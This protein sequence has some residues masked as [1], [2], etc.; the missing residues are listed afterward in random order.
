MCVCV[1]FASLLRCYVFNAAAHE[2]A[3]KRAEP[4]KRIS[5][6]AFLR[7]ADSPMTKE[8]IDAAVS[9][10]SSPRIVIVGATDSACGVSDSQPLIVDCRTHEEYE[11]CH[12]IT[13]ISFPI[14][15]MRQDRMPYALIATR[16]RADRLVVITDWDESG[17]EAVE[18]VTKL[19]QTGWANAVLLS[20][21]AV[22][23]IC[24]HSG[25]FV[26]TFHACISY[27]CI[28]SQVLKSLPRCSPT[29]LKG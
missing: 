29:S 17:G 10:T 9:Y 15:K 5:S 1:L 4:F 16:H 13:S 14:L 23:F 7:A 2:L 6:A 24:I 19:V 25:C 8:S 3:I 28:I 11:K 27:L 20:G 22:A 18:L 26:V 21:G 12:Y